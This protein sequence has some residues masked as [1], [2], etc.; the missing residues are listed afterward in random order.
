MKDLLSKLTG[1]QALDVLQR[2]EARKGAVADAVLAE[3][4]G[5]LAVVD[6]EEIANE[7]F[8]RLDMIDV[9]DC[10]DRAGRH[11][12]GYTGPE[13][14]AVQLLEEELQPFV[15][16][17]ERYRSLGMDKQE[18]E[19]CMGVILGTYRYDR[20]SKSEFKDW[21][22]DIPIEC[23]G[24]MLDEWRKVNRDDAATT[25]MDAFIRERCPGW[26][27]HLIR[28]DCPCAAG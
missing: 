28:S 7:G 9:Q 4:K 27:K 2:L 12:D 3:A 21:C 8:E 14:A 23:A 5:V 16:Q 26:A 20:E 24:D 17:V 6:V 25:A 19:Y 11:R 1:E 10:W 15:D 13:E 18:Q 22:A